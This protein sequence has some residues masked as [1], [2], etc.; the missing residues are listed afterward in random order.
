MALNRFAIL[1]A[2]P[3]IIVAAAPLFFGIMHSLRDYLVPGSEL[4]ARDFLRERRQE[5]KGIKARE[6]TSQGANLR[7]LMAEVTGSG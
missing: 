7:S 4:F 6:V 5:E 1:A 3:G 2:F